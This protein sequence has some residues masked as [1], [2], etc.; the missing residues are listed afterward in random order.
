MVTDEKIAKIKKKINA[1]PKERLD[2]LFLTPTEC[3]F[4]NIP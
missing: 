3:F 2:F 1:K 4:K